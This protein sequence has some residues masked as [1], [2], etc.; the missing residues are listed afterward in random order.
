[1]IRP[2]QIQT[3][4]APVFEQINARSTTEGKQSIAHLLSPSVEKMREAK[5]PRD[6]YKED[7]Q[8]FKESYLKAQQVASDSAK[9]RF[10]PV[11]VNKVT[12]ADWDD[13][14]RP[15]QPIN[16]M[17]ILNA[18]ASAANAQVNAEKP[19]P[20]LEKIAA[21][22]ENYRTNHAD[23]QAKQSLADKPEDQQQAFPWL[24]LTK[25]QF[26]AF[27]M[28][29]KL[30]EAKNFRP[31]I[32]NNL[33]D[34][35]HVIAPGI[36][37]NS[38]NRESTFNTIFRHFQRQYD[39]LSESRLRAESRT[40]LPTA[41]KLRDTP[42][43]SRTDEHVPAP[44]QRK[45]S[46]PFPEVKLESMPGAKKYLETPTEE[47]E[48]RILQ[49]NRRSKNFLD[50][51]DTTGMNKHAHYAMGTPLHTVFE[52]QEA[53]GKKELV[54]FTQGFTKH[55]D[56]M[57]K[58][59]IRARE[60]DGP[61]DLEGKPGKIILGQEVAGEIQQKIMDE[62]FVEQMHRKEDPFL[63]EKALQE[64][65]DIGVTFSS[66]L[67]GE[68]IGDTTKDISHMYKAVEKGVVQKLDGIFVNSAREKDFEKV[69]AR[70]EE[71]GLN[72]TNKQYPTVADAFSQRL[73]G[74]R[75]TEP[76]SV[77]AKR[78]APEDFVAPDGEKRPHYEAIYNHELA[79]AIT[80]A[81]ELRLRL[82]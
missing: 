77:P 61:N 25:E 60:Y 8:F 49:S 44:A 62:S 38:D 54:K 12:V 41:E 76:F 31:A 72:V 43:Q 81:K 5:T 22:L 33:I 80:R 58:T 45:F 75:S 64:M 37:L 11:V 1:M 70:A 48:V 27:A 19:N 15:E 74:D 7:N 57:Q 35:I 52:T 63:F 65:R 79:K 2:S 6:F 20:D 46:L 13:T 55:I 47:G 51:L 10:F 29:Q 42:A 67:E 40:T 50:E 28:D 78:L 18:V 34:N 4:L 3:A 24:A 30:E 71:A 9:R 32:V 26:V 39:E 73:D 16:Y 21:A 69:N 59:P 56:L 36:K 82:D 66:N 14:M 53:D 17:G 68:G 23:E